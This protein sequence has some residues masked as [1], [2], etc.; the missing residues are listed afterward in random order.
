MLHFCGGLDDLLQLL[1]L[2][3]GLCCLR[4]WWHHRKHHRTCGANRR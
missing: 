2:L 3:P 1:F 4:M